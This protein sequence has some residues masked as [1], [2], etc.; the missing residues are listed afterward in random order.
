MAAM[1][2]PP[3]FVAISWALCRTTSRRGFA[4]A[5]MLTS[6][7]QVT[8]LVLLDVSLHVGDTVSKLT[9]GPV[10]AEGSAVG[11]PSGPCV[12]SACNTI[13][14][15]CSERRLYSSA[16]YIVEAVSALRW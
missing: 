11:A 4:R 5:N 1:A 16:D 2:S 3:N 13:W 10:N 7:C 8:C 9:E 15:S 12:E 6:R 14:V